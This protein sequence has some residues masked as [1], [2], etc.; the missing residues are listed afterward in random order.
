MRLAAWSLFLCGLG[1][2]QAD[3]ILFQ[4]NF[5][6]QG[7]QLNTSLWTKLTGPPSYLGRTQLADWITTGGVG[8]FVVGPDGAHLTLN[9]F[10]PTGDSL[11]GTQGLTLQSFQPAADST[12]EFTTQLQ[13]TSL[14]PGI[15]YGMYLYGCNPNP[16]ATQHDEIDIELLTNTLR[17][18]TQSSEPL[19]VELNWYAGQPLG[20]G[21]GGLFNLPIGFNPLARHEWTIRWSL[22]AIEF[23]VDGTL[24]LSVD[25][26]VPH[27]PMNVNEIAWGPDTTWPA[28][29]DAS[30]QP[31]NS[32]GQNEAYTALLTGVTVAE[33]SKSLGRPR[34]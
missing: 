27:G 4:D 26:N 25:T 19:R 12:I 17:S 24:L 7:T 34:R 3:S 15:V 8:Q 22:K 32:A 18:S 21:N 11:Y 30:L 33:S 28:A 2:A 5:S 10:N 1:S 20:V 9:T 31:V 6:A 16:C 13:L 29:Y 14:E 23:Y